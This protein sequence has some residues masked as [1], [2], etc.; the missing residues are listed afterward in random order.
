M[1][2]W[3]QLVGQYKRPLIFGLV[4]TA[5]IGTGIGW[6]KAADLTG[7][8]IEV[9]SAAD[10]S[11]DEVKEQKIVIDMAGEVNKPG[12]YKLEFGSRIGEALE[13]AGGITEK[14][15]KEWVDRTLN[16]AEKVKDGQKIYIP[17]KN[18]Q[19]SM[20]NNQN[21]NSNNSKEQK[22]NINTASQSELE[23]LPGIGPATAKKLI[24]NRPYSEVSS[25]I[26]KKVVGEKVFGQIENQISV[27]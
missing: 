9:I 4:G 21:T 24:D 12:I 8:Q 11:T 6:W 5:L 2:G 25:L 22:I 3:E 17:S 7:E 13:I 19:E 16:K 23:N 1:P 18:N 27:Y 15:D 26:S 14:A 20:T 10:A